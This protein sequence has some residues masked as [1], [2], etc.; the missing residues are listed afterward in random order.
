MKWENLNLHIENLVPGIVT[1]ILVL[2]YL[3]A[4][5]LSIINHTSVSKIL[6]NSFI[7]GGLF[8]AISYLVGIFTVAICR[9]IIDPISSVCPRPLLFRW[10]FPEQFKCKSNKEIN[11][12]YRETLQK[13]LDS[14][15]EY[16]RSEM[17]N[18]RER[19]RL[20]RSSIL[21]MS[22]F[23]WIV[24]GN[25]NIF[26]KILVLIITLGISTFLYAYAELAIYQESV[27]GKTTES[28]D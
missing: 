28:G 15:S 19:G 12:A 5:A 6:G 8:V 10:F 13:G 4:N 24:I 27:V 1:S 25:L 3:P 16:K 22:L 17:K 18:R 23:I 9:L 11:F 7:A 21:P 14:E 26:I 20:L 2:M